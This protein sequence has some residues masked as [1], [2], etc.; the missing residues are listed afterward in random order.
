MTAAVPAGL[1]WFQRNKNASLWHQKAPKTLKSHAMPHL[2]F[3][4][5]SQIIYVPP[6]LLSTITTKALQFVYSAPPG[7]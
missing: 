7:P 2:L 3:L 1:H 4:L 5:T 6:F